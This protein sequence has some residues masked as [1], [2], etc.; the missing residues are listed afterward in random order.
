M[1]ALSALPHAPRPVRATTPR[2]STRG[3]G[4]SRPI[5][6]VDGITPEAWRGL[7]ADELRNE[8]I[9]GRDAQASPRAIAS[10]AGR[11]GNWSARHG[12]LARTHARAAS[13]RSTRCHRPTPSRAIDVEFESRPAPDFKF[14]RFIKRYRGGL[15]I[16]LLLVALD[17]LCTLAG[18]LLVRYGIDHGVVEQST[19]ALFAASFVFLAITLF[20][21]WVMWANARV[22]GRT[23]ERLLHALRIKVFAH[24]QRLGVDYYEQEMAGPDHDPHD[25]RHRRAVAR[26]CRTVSSTRS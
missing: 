9:A 14:L 19:E 13:R 11:G 17:A 1:G 10:P 25:H 18:P 3:R 20:D 26:C 24:L 16:G 2:G 22:M 21:W 7:D 23:S 5:G 4:R 15:S 8:Q 6:Q 12:R